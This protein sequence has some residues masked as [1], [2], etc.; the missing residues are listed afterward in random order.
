L[1]NIR[2]GNTFYIDTQ[3]SGASDALAIQ[4]VR[5][6]YIQISS[7]AA[8]NNAIL[9]DLTTGNIK[10]NFQNINNTGG[11]GD[12]RLFDFSSNPI[13]FPN[14]IKPVVLTNCSLTLFI[15]NPTG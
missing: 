3:Y 14:G 6:P 2:N 10:V 15:I 7:S 5:V 9:A 8:V 12:T 1:A 13:L 4:G 11:A